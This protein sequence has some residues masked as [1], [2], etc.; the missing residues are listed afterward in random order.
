MGLTEA[1]RGALGHWLKIENGVIDFVTY[2][3][4]YRLPELQCLMLIK[5]LEHLDE[6]VMDALK[7]METQ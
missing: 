3:Y 6:I 7:Q 2:G 4:N 1:P 5:Q